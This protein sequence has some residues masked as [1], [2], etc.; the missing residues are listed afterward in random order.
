MARSLTALALVAALGSASFAGPGPVSKLP[1][2]ETFQLDNGLRVAVLKTDASPAVTVGVW[3]H[4]GSKDEPRDRR[5]TARMFE[6]LMFKGSSHVRADWHAQAIAGLG[7]YTDAQADEDAT[8]FSDTLPASYVDFAI[9][10]EA[11]RM[12]NLMFRKAAVDNERELVKDKIRKQEASPVAKGLLKFL[13]VAYAKHPYAWTAA[14][15]P[16]ELD[17]TSIDD[18]HKFYDAYY[19]PNNALL[20]VVGNVS[21]D[22]VKASAN[23]WFAPIARAADP[24]RP[25]AAAPEPAQTAKKREVVEPGQLGITLVGWHVPAA[26]DKDIYPLQIASNVLG[27][28]EAARIKVRLKTPD[29]KTKRALALDG[30]LE[31]FVKED[32]GVMIAVGLY[33]EKDAADPVEAAI[34]DEVQK[35]GARGP[36]TDELRKAKNELESGFVFSL[37]HVQGLAD[38]LGRSWIQSGDPSSFVRDVDELEKVTAA[39]VERVVKQYM[40]PD[41]TTIVVIPPKGL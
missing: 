15:N 16:T 14:G 7:G 23:K 1:S 3:Y 12:R 37:E 26:K 27:R 20:V 17:A 31:S 28:G 19:Q 35:L 24:P 32:P 2:I 6:Q 29:P 21:L 10:L 9:Q 5:G 18:L 39:D 40:A 41:K 30:G 33:I 4:V 38:A 22:Q 25:A 34:L 13:A 11:E 8:H 36:T